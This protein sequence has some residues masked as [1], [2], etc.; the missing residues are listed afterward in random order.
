M[1]RQSRI[2]PDRLDTWPSHDEAVHWV[3]D[4][5]LDLKLQLLGEQPKHPIDMTRLDQWRKHRNELERCR[6]R[7][8]FY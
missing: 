2:A 7:L 8:R 3:S 6:Q 4:L 5:V 1:T